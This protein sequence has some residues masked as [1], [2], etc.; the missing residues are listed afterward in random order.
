MIYIQDESG[1]IGK[2]YYYYDKIQELLAKNEKC[3]KLLED[4]IKNGV[5]ERLITRILIKQSFLD[6][7]KKQREL[8]KISGKALNEYSYAYMKN[9][10]RYFL[11]TYHNSAFDDIIEGY[12]ELYDEMIEYFEEIT[13]G[14]IAH[15]TEVKKGLEA[16]KF[17][18]YTL[19]SLLE[20]CG[21]FFFSEEVVIFK[22][23][24]LENIKK[25][26]QARRL[27]EEAEQTK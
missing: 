10:F 5:K 18:L 16:G 24:E 9:D 25:E 17:Y 12:S 8:E 14:S 21:D 20:M 26:V 23:E 7:K 27:K 2:L 4:I 15:F 3:K 22:P 19:K 1:K 6:A 13:H 11:R